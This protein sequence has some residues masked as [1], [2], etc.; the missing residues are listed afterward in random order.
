MWDFIHNVVPCIVPA[1]SVQ[2]YELRVILK[3][4][5]LG[6]A[7][8]PHVSQRDKEISEIAPV[9][10]HNSLFLMGIRDVVR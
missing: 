6:L 5:T 1:R 9:S 7:G 10:L 3:F 2:S 8:Y 4:L